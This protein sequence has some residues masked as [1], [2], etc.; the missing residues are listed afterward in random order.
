MNQ[1]NRSAYEAVR[2]MKPGQVA[3]IRRQA[4]QHTPLEENFV[5][6]FVTKLENG[7]IEAEWSY[8]ASELD[9]RRLESSGMCGLETLGL[10]SCCWMQGRDSV[11][12]E[13]MVEF[14]TKYRY[15]IELLG[16]L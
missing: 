12:I 2:Q 6:R 4:S 14:D 3:V 13:R 10:D 16:V 11:S 9:E 15:E 1:S 7:K 5:Y 8:E